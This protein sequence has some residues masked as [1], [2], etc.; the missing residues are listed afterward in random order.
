[1]LNTT[2]AAYVLLDIAAHNVE[3]LRDK[4]NNEHSSSVKIIHPIIGPTDMICYVE[5]EG[6]KEFCDVLDNGIRGLV[7]TGDIVHTETMLIVSERF[8]GLSPKENNPVTEA[9]WLFIDISV[10][11]P[12]PVIEQLQNIDGVMVAHPVIGRYDIIVYVI[13]DTWKDLMN[14]LDNNIRHIKEITHTDTRL[15]LMKK[16]RSTIHNKS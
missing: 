13:G 2:F 15:V 6:Y 8:S 4:I 12:M 3:D 1:M 9:A 16:A 7:D 5:T 10:G 14:V 11:D